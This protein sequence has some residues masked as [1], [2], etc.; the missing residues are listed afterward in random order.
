MN[1]SVGVVIGTDSIAA[2]VATEDEQVVAVPAV[3]AVS[4][5]GN[6]MIGSDAER[7]A[8]RGTGTVYRNFIE[9]VGDPVPVI[10]TG[11]YACPG[12]DLAATSIDALLNGIGVDS[13]AAQVCVARPARWGVYQVS[14][15]RAAMCRT[16]VWGPATCMVSRPIAALAETGINS[17]ET[18]IVV[19]TDAWATEVSVVTGCRTRGGQVVETT[20]AEQLGVESLDRLLARHILAQLGEPMDLAARTELLTHC[21]GARDELARHTATTVPVR[22]PSGPTRVR[23]VRAEFESLVREPVTNAVATITRALARAR[24]HGVGVDGILLAGA[25]ARL[26]LLIETLSTRTRAQLTTPAD[27]NGVLAYGAQRLAARRGAAQ[28]GA[29][30][31]PAPRQPYRSVPQPLMA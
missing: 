6:L 25:A 22:L 17:A 23:V 27:P 15:L 13:S 16:G 29:G 30:V 9:R 5:E 19:D 21:A 7:I 4:S 3:L 28:P 12:A 10:G 26:P 24:E 1:G 18:V 14:A 11:D 20:L 8:H 2:T 31:A